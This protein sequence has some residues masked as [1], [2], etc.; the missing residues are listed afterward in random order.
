MFFLIYESL[1]GLHL[2]FTTSFTAGVFQEGD[3]GQSLLK[4]LALTSCRSQNSL[5]E[6]M[7]AKVA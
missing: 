2:C 1:Y 6:V 4:A 5:G 7:T 3:D